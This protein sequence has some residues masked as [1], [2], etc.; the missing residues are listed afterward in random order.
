MRYNYKLNEKSFES[1]NSKITGKE[2]LEKAELLP[3]EDFELLIKVNENG[4]EPVEL[5]EVIDLKNPGIEGFSAKP[6]EKLIIYVD[7][8][9]VKVEDSFLTPNEILALADKV[10]KD[11][12]LIQVKGETEIGYKHDREHKIAI[13]SGLVFISNEVDI[14]DINEHCQNGTPVPDD[15]KYKILIDREPYIV[16]EKCLT[17]REILLL[18][19]KTP[20]DRFQLRQK[21]KDGKVVTI[22]N[23]QK[24]CFTDPGIEKFKTIPL[25]QTEGEDI[26][27]RKE[28]ELL[29]EDK[30]FLDSLQLSWEAVK[31][32]NQ[33]WVLV[34]NYPIPNGYNVRTATIAIRIIGSYPI[35]GLDMVYFFPALSRV[36]QKP[37]GA[38]T[39][40]P[41]DGKTYQQWSRHRTSA[42]PWRADVD[43]LSTHIPLADFWLSN[44]FEKR[45]RNALSA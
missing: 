6:Y 22:K 44:E 4:Y 10:V 26:V 43:N 20:P 23:D 15:C 25:D 36:D 38:L 8:I 29:E 11:F 7:N 2:I 39:S 32:Q 13:V 3:V 37:I 12:Y 33:N 40:F 16:S 27:L 5:S 21:F 35:A 42:N 24:V 18:T 28:F 14:I 1:L 41:L 31:S 9:A 34:H 30:T 45:P 17:G 19:N